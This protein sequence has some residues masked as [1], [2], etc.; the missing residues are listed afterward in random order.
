MLEAE[1]RLG[2]VR[3]GWSCHK[4]PNKDKRSKREIYLLQLDKKGHNEAGAM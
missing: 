4:L 2:Q 3:P 1:E